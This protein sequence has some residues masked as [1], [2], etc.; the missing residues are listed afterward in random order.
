MELI[1]GAAFNSFEL[2]EALVSGQVEVLVSV[3]YLT[4]MMAFL[5]QSPRSS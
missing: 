3:K 5:N 4:Q 1:C 2:H